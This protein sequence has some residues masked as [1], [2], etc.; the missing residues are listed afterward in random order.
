MDTLD[1][2]SLA[3][4]GEDWD[5]AAFIPGVHLVEHWGVGLGNV[6]NG[7][8]AISSHSESVI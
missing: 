2:K 1:C 6:H 8:K 4:V 7:E 5:H 3:E